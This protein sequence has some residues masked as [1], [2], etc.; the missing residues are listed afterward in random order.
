MK[1]KKVSKY[2]TDFCESRIWKLD[3]DTST[4]YIEKMA[5]LTFA[6]EVNNNMKIICLW[7]INI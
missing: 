4:A 3:N 7:Q 5:T 1:I 2:E 6:F